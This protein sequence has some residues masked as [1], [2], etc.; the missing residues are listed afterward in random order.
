[1]ELWFSGSGALA[2]SDAAEKRIRVS[3]TG[4]DK[5]QLMGVIRSHFDHIHETMNMKKQEHVFEQVPC[6]CSQCRDTGKPHFFDY[7]M[8]RRLAEKGMDTHCNKSLE[9]ISPGT[10]LN[11]FLPAGETGNFFDTLV[12]TLSQLQGLKK[13]LLPHEN[14]RNTVVA[15]LLRARGHRV[16]DQTLAGSSETGEGLGEL[17]IKIEDDTGRAVS[18]IEALD[19]N[20]LNT[21]A[22]D[23]H[24]RKLFH[25]YDCSGLKE[26]YI[27]VYAAV[28]DFEGFCEKYREHLEQIDYESYPMKGKIAAKETGLNKIAAYQARHRCRKS[29]TVLYHL[30]V[31]M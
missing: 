9:I 20:S 28:K 4:S 24:I 26:N 31:E 22:I 19:L 14:E 11:G 30:L 18:I 16:L 1:V 25:N 8:L 6:T 21:A 27:V 5:A 3:V 23:S 13:T 15:N 29:E 17:D 12:T 10:L 2:V 7:D